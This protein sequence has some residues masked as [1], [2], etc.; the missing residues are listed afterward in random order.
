MK[1][2]PL[3]VMEKDNS[4]QID[5]ANV[6]QIKEKLAEKGGKPVRRTV[7]FVSTRAGV[8]KEEIQ[9]VVPNVQTMLSQ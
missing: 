8:G 6:V 2:D 4:C 5:L 3:Y 9:A 1:P 7:L